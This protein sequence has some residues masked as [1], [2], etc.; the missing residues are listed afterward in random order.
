MVLWPESIQARSKQEQTVFNYYNLMYLFF[1][2]YIR[3]NYNA[4]LD[5]VP[6]LNSSKQGSNTSVGYCLKYIIFIQVFIFSFF[7]LFS[8]I[9]LFSFPV[10]MCLFMLSFS[11]FYTPFFAFLSH[12]KHVVFVVCRC[13]VFERCSAYKCARRCLSARIIN[14]LSKWWSILR[15]MLHH[16]LI[17]PLAEIRVRF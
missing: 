8:N 16:L 1:L 9:L 2:H 14:F 6:T 13:L 15:S 11:V 12:V 7:L 5:F 3:S 17:L 4:K 10:W